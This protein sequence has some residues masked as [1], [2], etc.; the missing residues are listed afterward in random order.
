MVP[1]MP[2]KRCRFAFSHACSRSSARLGTTAVRSSRAQAKLWMRRFCAAHSAKVMRDGMCLTHV[3]A[4]ATEGSRE[5]P[6]KTQTRSS[7]R[8][9]GTFS[10]RL[11]NR[12][13]TCD[14]S[15]CRNLPPSAIDMC[16]ARRIAA[17]VP[18]WHPVGTRASYAEPSGLKA[19]ES[20]SNSAVP[21]QME[22][23]SNTRTSAA[24]LLC[25]ASRGFREEAHCG[26]VNKV[27][28]LQA[29]P[30][31]IGLS[32]PWWCCVASRTNAPTCMRCEQA[33][34]F[35]RGSSS[36]S[37]NDSRSCSKLFTGAP[38]QRWNRHVAVRTMTASSCCRSSGHVGLPSWPPMSKGNK[39]WPIAVCSLAG[40]ASIEAFH[41]APMRRDLASSSAV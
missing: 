24:L 11:S 22:A 16:P 3:D 35:S 5:R 33:S 26:L 4:S 38:L 9:C 41:R 39:A 27:M 19:P 25:H 2:I 18:C 37:Q 36:A 40:G 30:V 8:A 28:A 10:T 6:C 21:A 13:R 7:R 14:A 20:S 31:E 34:S 17:P 15:L 29:P 12:S 32:V 1:S 23:R